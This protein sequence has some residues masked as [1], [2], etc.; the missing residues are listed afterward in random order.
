MKCSE[1]MAGPR[2]GGDVLRRGESRFMKKAGIP[3]I[4]GKSRA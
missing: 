3:V 4:C 1:C 2:G